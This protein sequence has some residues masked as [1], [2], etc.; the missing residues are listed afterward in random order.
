MITFE[1]RLEIAK[2]LENSN[3]LF[4]Q[5]WDIGTPTLTKSTQLTKTAC[6]AFDLKGNNIA[7]L[8]NEDFWN[9]LDVYTRAFIAGHEMLHVLLSHGRRMLLRKDDEKSN[10]ALDIV[11]NHLLVDG[12]GFDRE[13]LCIDWT[14]YYWVDTVF[15]DDV[16]PPTNKS[17][18]HYYNLMN[19]PENR[20]DGG[21]GKELM[22]GHGVEFNDEDGI[23][24]NAQS[25]IC[26][27]LSEFLTV[28]DFDDTVK[29]VIKEHGEQEL[30]PRAGTG[31][32]AWIDFNPSPPKKTIKK[33]EKILKPTRKRL[34]YDYNDCNSWIR[35]NKRLAPFLEED[36]DI[37]LETEVEM[38]SYYYEKKAVE[39]WFFLDYSSS[40]VE[41]YDR[42]YNAVTTLNQNKFDVK[43]YTFDTKA[44]EL[45]NPNKIYGGGGTKFQCI[46]DKI[47]EDISKGSEYPESVFIITD[48][49]GGK[50]KT[51]HPE[52]WHWF[53][54][55]RS[56]DKHIPQESTTYKL[57]DFE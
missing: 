39:I 41:Y 8:W 9:S 7:F 20:S 36:T 3:S 17:Y 30:D 50:V 2:V 47:L 23:C 26:E 28:D 37:F 57:K 42:F 29:D 15:K 52:R 5:F 38:E 45:T 6:V 13:K 40:C 35:E 19:S 25:K 48:G 18:E 34:V 14:K 53:M 55:D 24:P 1:D 54:T 32:G 11:V 21:K 12:F 22:D 31:I 43:K 46:E 51:R 27:E 49:Y 44:V 4:R 56:T 33:W 16:I 10:G